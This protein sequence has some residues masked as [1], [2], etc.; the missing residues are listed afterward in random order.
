MKLLPPQDN[1]DMQTNT[2]SPTG[3]RTSYPIA[4]LPLGYWYRRNVNL[5]E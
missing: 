4:P 2:H 3:F 5:P 1:T